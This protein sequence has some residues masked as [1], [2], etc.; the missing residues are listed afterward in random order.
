MGGLYIK[1]FV[2][3]LQPRKLASAFQSQAMMSAYFDW[4]PV[5]E[6]GNMPSEKL[7]QPQSRDHMHQQR[8]ESKK[9]SCL[10]NM[11]N[12]MLNQFQLNF[13]GG[14][15]FVLHS[16]VRY[17]TTNER[18]Q[19]KTIF[20]SCVISIFNN[21]EHSQHSKRIL[22]EHN[23]CY[24]FLLHSLLQPCKAAAYLPFVSGL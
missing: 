19:W 5:A 21:F 2:N 11:Y 6:G 17:K 20:Q 9:S 8:Y 15:K 4:G 14:S 10:E 24:R 3:L 16:Q 12:E 23:Q 1:C 13:H 22:T 7:I 18:R